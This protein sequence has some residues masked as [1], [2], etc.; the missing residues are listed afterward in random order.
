MEI[1]YQSTVEDSQL[2]KWLTTKLS[3]LSEEALTKS[4]DADL[5][6]RSDVF[7]LST[8]ISDYFS[9]ESIAHN[10]KNYSIVYGLITGYKADQSLSQQEML[11]YLVSCV[12]L[13]QN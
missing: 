10:E 9:Q 13:F 5:L 3:H 7:Q 11:E 4:E 12:F 1:E 2:V 8:L 6:D